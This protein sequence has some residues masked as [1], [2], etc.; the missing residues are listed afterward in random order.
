MGSMIK[1]AI[2]KK[3][4][5]SLAPEFMQVINESS[6]HRVPAGSETHFKVVL[7]SE[8]LRGQSTLERHQT[9]FRLLDAE[10]KAGIHA[11]SIQ[12][13]TPEEWEK[14]QGQVAASPRCLGGDKG[15]H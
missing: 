9:V 4:Q 2:E 7:A 8:K 6:N 13:F 14:R 11:L 5:D 15:K 3:L 10:M 12:A 1:E